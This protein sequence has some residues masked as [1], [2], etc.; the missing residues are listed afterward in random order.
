M[1]HVA[2]RV[3]LAAIKVSS[4]RAVLLFPRRIYIIVFPEVVEASVISFASYAEEV[5]NQICFIAPT[6]FCVNISGMI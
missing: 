2:Q 6:T 5:T 3:D 1:L 4:V